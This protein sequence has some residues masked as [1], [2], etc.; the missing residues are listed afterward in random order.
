MNW[1]TFESEL[2]NKL[3][4]RAESSE[5]SPGT[6]EEEFVLIAREI[7][8]LYH[9]VSI[10]VVEGTT[11]TFKR[12]LTTGVGF[13]EG[14]KPAIQAAIFSS[15]LTMQ[16]TNIKPN[17]AIMS[18]IGAAVV[19]YWSTVMVPASFSS[20]P[21]PPQY[22][23]LSSPAPGVLVI[24]PGNPLPVTNGFKNAFTSNLNIDTQDEAYQ[25]MA[26]DIRDGFESHMLSITGT[27]IGLVPGIPP[28]PLPTPW[29]GLTPT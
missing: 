18:P 11:A 10:S 12:P 15:L 3:K 17:M 9:Q 20:F 28:F 21:T 14:A 2:V 26:K 4:A 16:K 27:Y 25:R 19:A 1:A 24:F 23:A 6:P 29:T 5:D 8:D 13:L 22:A 7:T